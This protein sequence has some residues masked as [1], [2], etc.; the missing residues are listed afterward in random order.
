VPPTGPGTE[1][2]TGDK[3]GSTGKDDD[4]KPEDEE[5]WKNLPAEDVARKTKMIGDPGPEGS[6]TEE[7]DYAGMWSSVSAD[8]RRQIVDAYKFFRPS[9]VEKHTRAGTRPSPEEYMDFAMRMGYV[10]IVDAEEIRAAREMA[11]AG[12]RGIAD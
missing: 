7:T 5:D 3:K 8:K 10:R 4:K 2:P 11:D 12:G 9:L 1:P 6:M